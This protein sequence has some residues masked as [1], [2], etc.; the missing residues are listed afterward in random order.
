MM[1]DLATSGQAFGRGTVASV[2]PMGGMGPIVPHVEAGGRGGVEPTADEVLE[3]GHGARIEDG[4]GSVVP[5]GRDARDGGRG[6]LDDRRGG[7]RG[8][9]RV[10]VR[11]EGDAR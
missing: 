7:R 11:L 10:D 3:V 1:A 9:C 2:D 6:E 8:R 5:L 4:V